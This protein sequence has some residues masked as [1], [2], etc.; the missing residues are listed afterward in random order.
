MD[1]VALWLA[2]AGLFAARARREGFGRARIALALGLG[3]VTA[4]LGWATLYFETIARTPAWLISINGGFSLAFVAAGVMLASG[5]LGPRAVAGSLRAL[6]PAIGVAKGACVLA[7]CCGA[8]LEGTGEAE[9]AWLPARVLQLV[10]ASACL[11]LAALLARV[12]WRQVPPAFALGHWGLRMTSEAW[13]AP[14]AFGPPDLPLAEVLAGW[15]LLVLCV[16]SASRPNGSNGECQ[17][18]HTS[19]DSKRR[20]PVDPMPP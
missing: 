7:G 4:R 15:T 3:V 6:A 1:G 19:A 10:E 20:S 2:A 14:P 9:A 12:G 16:W 8:A 18:L 13:R 5:P 17:A 11:A